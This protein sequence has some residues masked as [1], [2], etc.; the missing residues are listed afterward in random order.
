MASCT[1]TWS[2]LLLTAMCQLASVA[3]QPV[4]FDIVDAT[5]AEIHEAFRTGNLTSVMLTKM[6][7]Q[8]RTC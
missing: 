1:A 4:P 2:V 5:V 7:L 8:V 3:S 6:Y